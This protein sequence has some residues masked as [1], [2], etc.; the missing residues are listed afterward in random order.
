MSVCADANLEGFLPRVYKLV[1]LEFGTLDESLATLSA[2]V[3]AGTVSV[4]MLPHGGVIPEHLCA[5]L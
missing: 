4:E 3:H 1:T 5:T 2:D